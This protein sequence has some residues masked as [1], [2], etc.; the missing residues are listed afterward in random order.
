MNNLLPMPAKPMRTFIYEPASPAT[1]PAAQ[2][3]M[4]TI[5]LIVDD[6]DTFCRVMQ[7]AFAR[8]AIATDIFTAAAPALAAM[9]KV[10]YKRAIIDLKI[11]QDSGLALIRSLK[12][13]NPDIQIIMLTGYSSVT[14]A[15]EAIK[16]GALNYLCKPVAVDDILKAFNEGLVEPEIPLP[17]LPPS[18]DRM[19]WELIQKALQDNQGNI[20]AT[21]RTLGMHRR[22]LQRKLLKRPASN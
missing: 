5:T 19:E 21:A 4:Q 17:Q 13:L 6:D 16:S 14:T 15:V 20:S 1:Q 10:G 12:Q 8:R 22:T 7:R 3:T 18:L 11:A 2:T 9:K